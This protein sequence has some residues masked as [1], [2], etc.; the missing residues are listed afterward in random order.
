MNWI[1]FFAGL[2]VGFVVALIWK[3]RQ[4]KIGRVFY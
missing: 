1:I 3:A 2:A 4:G